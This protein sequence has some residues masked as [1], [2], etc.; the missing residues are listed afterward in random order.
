MKISEMI[1][2]LQA[3]K[4]EDGDLDI[5]VKSENEQGYN[6]DMNVGASM[7]WLQWYK[8]SSF[9]EY[10]KALPDSK[11]INKEDTVKKFVVIE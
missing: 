2:L 9:Y 10:W 5:A 4:K 8:H 3:I 6:Y 1:K 11:E 7:A